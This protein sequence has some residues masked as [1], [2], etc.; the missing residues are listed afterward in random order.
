LD[1]WNVELYWQDE[2]YFVISLAGTILQDGY[3]LV[4]ASDK[5]LNLD[6]NYANLGGKLVNSGMKVILKNSIGEVVD[7]VDARE[8]WL[9]G[10][11]GTKRTMERKAGPGPALW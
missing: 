6:T 3:F 11:N 7:E 8:G 9:A 2:L 4:G 10:D 5:I 1:G